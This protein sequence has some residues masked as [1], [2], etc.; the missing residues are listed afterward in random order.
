MILQTGMYKYINSIVIENYRRQEAFREG[1]YLTV[2]L[3][4][5]YSRKQSLLYILSF[6]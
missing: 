2:A 1:L 6:F 3:N 5:I 4:K